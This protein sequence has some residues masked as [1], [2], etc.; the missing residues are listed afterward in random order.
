MKLIYE[1]MICETAYNFRLSFVFKEN[2]KKFQKIL[3]SILTI[4]NESV[5]INLDNIMSN[6][7]GIKNE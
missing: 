1:S 3:D 2:T 4:C 6:R 7:E 5:I